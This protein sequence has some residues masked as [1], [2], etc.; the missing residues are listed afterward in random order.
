MGHASPK[1]AVG[2]G[3]SY[4]WLS[5]F[6][7]NFAVEFFF[8]ICFILINARILMCGIEFIY[9][10]F[11]VV[12]SYTQLAGAW[13]EEFVP[14]FVSLLSLAVIIFVTLGISASLD[15]MEVTGRFILHGGGV[16]LVAFIT[17][18]ATLFLPRPFR[19]SSKSMEEKMGHTMEKVVRKAVWAVWQEER[20][21]EKEEETES[22]TWVCKICRRSREVVP[23]KKDEGKDE[24]KKSASLVSGDSLKTSKGSQEMVPLKSALSKSALQ[25][26]KGKEVAS[27]GGQSAR[28]SLAE[29][30][31]KH[32]HGSNRSNS[33][34][35]STTSDGKSDVVKSSTSRNPTTS[36]S[37]TDSGQEFETNLLM[38]N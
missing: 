31:G 32:V 7:G 20:K 36:E 19:D 24:E 11:I 28:K 29:S 21:K 33:R 14:V 35:I 15:E 2:I 22:G 17:L 38:G 8:S 23:L 12:S 4:Y 27:M 18:V 34:T 13:W 5:F 26:S 1:K 37:K 25:D 16:F 10:T 9:L 30:R 3:Y 6:C